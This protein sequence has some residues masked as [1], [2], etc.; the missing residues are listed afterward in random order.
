MA[1]TCE[2]TLALRRALTNLIVNGVKYG[3]QVEVELVKDNNQVKISI[4]D[5]GEGIPD[6]EL[7]QVFLPFYRVDKARQD[8]T[9]G[10]GLGLTVARDIIRSHGGDIVLQNLPTHGLCAT[11]HLPLSDIK[12]T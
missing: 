9:G 5:Q 2:R 1:Q 10:S 6:S 8:N 11:V 4:C 3:K 12:K 7:E